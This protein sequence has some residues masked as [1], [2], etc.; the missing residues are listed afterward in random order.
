MYTIIGFVLLIMVIEYFRSDDVIFAI[1]LNIFWQG[2]FELGISNKIYNN[3]DSS[4][5]REFK[6]G[7]LIIN[8]CFT[9]IRNEA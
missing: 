6:I 1:E 5:E 2:S 4:T 3:D 9:F 8:V 7:L